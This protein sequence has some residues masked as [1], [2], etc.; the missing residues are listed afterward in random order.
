MGLTVSL[1]VVE[2]SAPV[3]DRTSGFQPV[4]SNF[5]DWAIPAHKFGVLQD[6]I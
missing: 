1:D 4:A 5:I 6:I 3:G 2:I